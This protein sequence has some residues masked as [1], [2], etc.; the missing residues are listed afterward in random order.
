MF[1]SQTNYYGVT[2]AVRNNQWL[3]LDDLT[4]GDICINGMFFPGSRISIQKIND[5]TSHT[6]A[7]GE[8]TYMLSTWMTGAV[9]AGRKPKTICNSPASNVRYPINASNNQFGYHKAD[10]EAPPGAPKTMQTN[11][12]NFGSKHT[13]GAQFCFADGSVHMLSDAMDF[14][15]LEDMA[16]IAGHESNHSTP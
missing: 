15:L 12:L 14:T 1:P 8:R 4:C 6:L 3:D 9:W 5:G 16:T 10:G 11:D 2:G 7:V 13:D